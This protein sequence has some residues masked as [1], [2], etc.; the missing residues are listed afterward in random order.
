MHLSAHPFRDDI[1]LDELP[2]RWTPD[3]VGKR[4]IEAFRTLA[5]M[6]A[7]IGPDGYRSNWPEYIHEFA[8]LRNQVEGGTIR[9]APRPAR[10]QPTSAE[11]SAMEKA[12][13]WP[14]ERLPNADVQ[15]RQ[16]L[17]IW[18][19]ATAWE[20]NQGYLMHRFGWSKSQWR[21]RRLQALELIAARLADGKIDVF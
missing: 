9:T 8:D 7:K 2:P 3:H 20:M 17:L 10:I 13:A 21:R 19:M 5:R 14:L 15:M 18:A 12:L 11:I 4:L 16:M 1:D 6:P